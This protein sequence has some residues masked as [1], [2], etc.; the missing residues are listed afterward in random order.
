MIKKLSI[1]T[2]HLGPSQLSYEIISSGNRA[3]ATHK[4]LDLIVFPMNTYISPILPS[5]AVMNSSELYDHKSLTIATDIGL[6]EMLLTFPGPR[7]RV[8][9]SHDLDW[10]RDPQKNYE[11]YARIYLNRDL[12]IFVRSN[13]HRD[14]F[15]SVW[16][17][18]VKVINQED[19][20]GEFYKYLF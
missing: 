10:L 11:R 6:M 19:V 4:D 16:N 1:L 8:L 5:F 20:V 9:Y 7:P 15:L 13:T 3:V 14:I 2:R 17:R 18:E 12:D